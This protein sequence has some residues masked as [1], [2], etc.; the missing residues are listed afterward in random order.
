MDAS[1]FQELKAA[2][3]SIATELRS[4]RELAQEELEDRKIYTQ[5]AQEERVEKRRMMLHL[6]PYF[7]YCK[8]QM[9]CAG[10]VRSESIGDNSVSKDKQ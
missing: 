2:L 9:Q 1:L 6:E 7:D 4:M 5:L 10:T 8:S 3:C